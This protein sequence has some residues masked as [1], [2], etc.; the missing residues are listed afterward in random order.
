MSRPGDDC[1]DWHISAGK[2]LGG[3][4]DVRLNVRPMLIT[5]PFACAAESTLNLV[6]DQQRFIFAAQALRF[7]QVSVGDHFTALALQRLQ[8]ESCGGPSRQRFFQRSQIVER[9]LD[10]AGHQLAETFAKEIR[11][12]DRQ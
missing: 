8:D 10:G 3:A 1:A 2:R 9:D 5:E 11:A 6:E 7:F 12:V 4:D